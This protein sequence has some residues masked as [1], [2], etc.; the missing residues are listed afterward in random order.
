LAD[1]LLEEVADDLL[2][3]GEVQFSTGFS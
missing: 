2:G 3:D 1:R